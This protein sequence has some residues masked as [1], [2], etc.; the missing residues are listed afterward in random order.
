[1]PLRMVL[2]QPE[3]Q[4][5]SERAD[6]RAAGKIDNFY[7]L[8]IGRMPPVPG[9]LAYERDTVIDLKTASASAAAGS[10]QAEGFGGAAN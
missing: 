4:H 3:I 7:G 1:M 10:S 8:L 2:V 6:W 5:R 9:V